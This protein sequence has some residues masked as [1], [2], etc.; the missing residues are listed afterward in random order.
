MPK[1]GKMTTKKA[2]GN[3][4][5][6]ANFTL[7]RVYLNTRDMKTKYTMAILATLMSVAAVAQEDDDMYFNAKDRAVLNKSVAQ[8]MARRYQEADQQ[9]IKTNPVN[10]S[11]SYSGRG[12]N[13]EYGAQ[14]R[15]GTT[16]V[17][18]NPN[19]FVSSYQPQNVNSSL[20]GNNSYYNTNP[21]SYGY[22]NPYLGYNGYGGMGYSGFGS[23]FGMYSP[24]SSMGLGYG[25]GGMGSGWYGG[26]GY[27]MGS[28]FSPFGSYMG[29]GM[30]SMYNPF[31]M[32]YGMGY[33]YS[34]YNGYPG[35]GYSGYAV[36]A[37]PNAVHG[38]HSVRS[39]TVNNYVDNS[40]GAY[41][42]SSNG[43]TRASQMGRSSQN[44][45]YD[46]SWRS[47]PNNY[48]RSDYN[49]STNNSGTTRSSYDN[50]WGNSRSS[51][52]SF[53]NG[54]RGGFSGGGGSG[55]S[56]GGGHSSGGSGGG[57]GGHSRGRN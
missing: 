26:M 49:N 55:S 6:M 29:Y 30:M 32:G 18:D 2:L 23:P 42:T 35:Y 3:G 11:D 22:N 37:E 7:V 28:M 41:T 5:I 1:N 20:Y 19:Y 21:Y 8:V 43:T 44:N 40:R 10:P 36:A 51:F 16:L 53:G 31:G 13:P 48:S 47:N 9:A 25:M 34:S 57:G 54:S 15:N 39:S 38:R 14:A 33:G 45:Y 46:Q 12:V 56:G 24:Y 27:G 4:T 52:D 50:S 17:Q